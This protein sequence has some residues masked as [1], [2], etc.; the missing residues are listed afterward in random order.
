MLFWMLWPTILSEGEVTKVLRKQRKST[1]SL[2]DDISHNNCSRRAPGLWRG[3][4]PIRWHRNWRRGWLAT[5]ESAG[6]TFLSVNSSC[7]CNCLI[8]CGSGKLACVLNDAVNCKINNL[9]W[10]DPYW[11][12]QPFYWSPCVVVPLECY[13]TFCQKWP[14][15]PI[16]KNP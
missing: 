14:Y 4:N 3:Q 12:L 5:G 13:I 6:F 1:R 16:I 11:L 15:F 10:H 7:G 9:L 2:T 8:P